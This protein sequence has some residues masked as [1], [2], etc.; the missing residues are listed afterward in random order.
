M[1]FVR[2]QEPINARGDLMSKVV[3]D[4]GSCE[5]QIHQ[6]FL[7]Q[8]ICSLL[9]FGTGH[10][11]RHGSDQRTDPIPDRTIYQGT[12]TYL[13]GAVTACLAK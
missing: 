4:I 6:F 1:G 13:W 12:A 11:F 5:N 7:N 9:R 2:Q 3:S 10:G 8:N